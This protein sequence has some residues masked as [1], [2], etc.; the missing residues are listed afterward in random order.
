M[1]CFWD[2]IIN[3]LNLNNMN[4]QSLVILLKNNCVKTDSVYWNDNPITEQQM[5]ENKERIKI[6]YTNTLSLRL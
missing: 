4:A 5:Q 1:T 2:G 6:Q 3:G